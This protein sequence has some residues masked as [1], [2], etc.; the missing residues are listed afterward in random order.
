MISKEFLLF[1]QILQAVE[2]KRQFLRSFAEKRNQVTELM[3]K[4]EDR[5]PL[6]DQEIKKASSALLPKY[7]SL[8]R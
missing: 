1:K 3:A 6:F 4:D 5:L 8:F 7:E 2:E